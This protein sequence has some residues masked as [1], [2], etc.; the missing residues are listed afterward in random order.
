VKIQF[1]LVLKYPWEVKYMPDFERM[2][3]ALFART[4]DAVEALERGE[5]DTALEILIKAQL[6]GEE[7]YISE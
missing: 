2:Y 1:P 6:E 4:A 3:F 5:G 7:S